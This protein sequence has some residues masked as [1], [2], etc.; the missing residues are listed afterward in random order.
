MKQPGVVTDN[1]QWKALGMAASASAQ[2]RFEGVSARRI[3]GERFYLDRPGFWHG[4]AGIAASWHGATCAIAEYLRGQAQAAPDPG[5]HRLLA[6]GDIDRLLSAN[7]A[8]LH[9]AAAWID[10]HPRENARM[11]ALR[12]RAATEG[13]ADGVLRLASRAMGAGPLCL[14]RHYAQLAADLPVYIRQCHGDRDLAALGEDV[15]VGEEHPWAL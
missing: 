4:G 12:V 3:G 5:W 11:W 1:R 10:A 14:D 7:A 9:E 13:A 6:L 15:L 8:L 2:V